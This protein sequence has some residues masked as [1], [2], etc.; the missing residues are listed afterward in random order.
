MIFF[1]MIFPLRDIGQ[2]YG[3][4]YRAGDEIGSSIRLC[5]SRCTFSF[6]A[7]VEAIAVRNSLIIAD[8]SGRVYV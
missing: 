5:F 4:S 6:T 2:T 3:F 7:K 1:A 8:Y